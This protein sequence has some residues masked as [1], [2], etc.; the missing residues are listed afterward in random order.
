MKEESVELENMKLILAESWGL[1]DY[2]KSG[3]LYSVCSTWVV[4]ANYSHHSR[5]WLAV[6]GLSDT[7][8]GGPGPPGKLQEVPRPQ[9]GQEPGRR[10]AGMG[11]GGGG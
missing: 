6:P 10:A 1:K 2:V 3:N 5:Y 4:Q 11:I 7:G 8:Q 9:G